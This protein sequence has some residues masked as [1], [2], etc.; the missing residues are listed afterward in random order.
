MHF[1]LNCIVLKVLKASKTIAV[2]Y[3]FQTSCE[4]F[5]LFFFQR[6]ASQGSNS[7]NLVA[8]INVNTVKKKTFMKGKSLLMKN[9]YEEHFN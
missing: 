2:V 3:I 9:I 4:V 1:V 6:Q 8:K 5:H 7:Q